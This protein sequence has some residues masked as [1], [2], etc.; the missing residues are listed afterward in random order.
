M[1]K[2]VEVAPRTLRWQPDFLSV[3]DAWVAMPLYA[4]EVLSVSYAS[5][6]TCGSGRERSE[7]EA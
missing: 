4:P 7:P 2:T 3:V 6:R 1:G 5:Y